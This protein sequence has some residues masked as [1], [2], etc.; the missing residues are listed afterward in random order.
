MAIVKIFNF[1]MPNGFTMRGDN[2]FPLELLRDEGFC[3]TNTDLEQFWPH[4][5]IGKYDFEVKSSI[6]D[7]TTNN[8]SKIVEDVQNNDN[9]KRS[10]YEVYNVDASLSC[11]S[12]KRRLNIDNL[13]DKDS[14]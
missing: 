4:E 8:E 2:L 7:N 3:I 6:P 1:V 10:V 5:L 12:S 11:S 9:G 13:G 14:S